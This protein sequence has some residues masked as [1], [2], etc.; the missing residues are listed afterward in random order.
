MPGYNFGFMMEYGGMGEDKQA[1][2]CVECRQCEEKCPQ[3]I[4]ISHQMA[5][6][7]ETHKTAEMSQR[8]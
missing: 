6:I 4:D 7:Q 8:R 5:L 1:Q 2:H 3:H